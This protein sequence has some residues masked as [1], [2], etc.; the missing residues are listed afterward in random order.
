MVEFHKMLTIAIST[1]GD[2]I[3][4]IN[5][6][7]FDRRVRYIILWQSSRDANMVLPSNVRL[8]KL[9]SIG[10]THSRNKA[11][12]SCDT[13]WIW[14]MDDDVHITEDVITYLLNSLERRE[15]N[16]VIISS[17]IDED[18]H[19]M[20]T[21]QKKKSN[22]ILD[23]LNVGTIQIIL[24]NNIV[25]NSR[26][27]FPIFM[28]AGNKYP[29]CDEPIF[30]SRLL[31]SKIISGFV[32]DDKLTISHPKYSSGMNLS[33]K[34]QLISRAILFREVFGFPLCVMASVL[35]F[36]KNYALIGSKARFL[37]SFW[38]KGG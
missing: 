27:R 33:G 24:N 6:Y 16:R 5:Q 8:E 2:R 14:F 38:K 29:A 21:Y 26:V 15:K 32:F 18:G 12:N 4:F 13:E 19:P 11:I 25:K 37:F 22:S 28:G 10:V 3:D 23:V 1:F 35:F 34:G 9:S 7:A 36:I 31:K 20:K 30:L 17:V